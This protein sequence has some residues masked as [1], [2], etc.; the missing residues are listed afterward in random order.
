MTKPN[1]IDVWQDKPAWC[2][3]WTIILTGITLISASWLL[4]H[5]LWLSI[6]IASLILLRWGYF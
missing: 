1:S 2:Q 6:P 3:P 5:R 4:F